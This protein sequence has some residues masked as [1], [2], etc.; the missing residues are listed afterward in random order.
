MALDAGVAGF[1]VPAMASEVHQLTIA[2]K[3][4]MVSIVMDETAGRVPVFAG[5]G[6]TDLSAGLEMLSLYK[7]IGCKHA[8][9]QLPFTNANEFKTSFRKLCD[10]G[11]EIIMLQDWD[12]QGYGLPDELILD[13][14]E[15]VPNF[16]CLKIETVPAGVKYSRLK[17][18]T[19]GR[20]HLSGGWAVMQMIEGL[21]RGLHAFMPT[22]MHYIYTAIYRTYHSGDKAKAEDI[23]NKVLPVLAFSNQHLHISI[24]FFKR[25][26]YR[27]GIYSTSMVRQPIQAFDAVHEAIADKLIDHVLQLED[28]LKRGNLPT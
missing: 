21:S 12:T 25:L 1:L 8:L 27:Q 15:T 10:A 23:F 7:S 28:Q 20:L 5:A 3:L 17:E 24:H 9:I 11:P 14:F 4:K 13:L 18:L 26:L 22:G 2:E 6:T 19:G 16:R